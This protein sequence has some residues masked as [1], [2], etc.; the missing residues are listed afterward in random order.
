V[1][2]AEQ[3]SRVVTSGFFIQSLNDSTLAISGRGS[4]LIQQGLPIL[5]GKF[6]RLGLIY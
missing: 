5:G 6:V 1:A 4:E 2:A 3:D